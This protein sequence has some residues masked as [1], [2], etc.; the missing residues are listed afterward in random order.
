MFGTVV[1]RKEKELQQGRVVVELCMGSR[2]HE[3]LFRAVYTM[4]E[5]EVYFEPYFLVSF[6]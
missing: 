2:V 6:I 5:S 4:A 3:D 1:E